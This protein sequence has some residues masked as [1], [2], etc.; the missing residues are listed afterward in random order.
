MTGFSYPEG[1]VAILAAWAN[2]GFIAARPVA[3]TWLPLAVFEAQ[4][5][6]ALPLRKE[7]LRRRGVFAE[8]HSRGASASLP[9]ST[10]HILDL[11]MAELERTFERQEPW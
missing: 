10:L 6:L 5:G 3:A 11:Q 4:A 1:L 9:P 8:A 2:G 7:I